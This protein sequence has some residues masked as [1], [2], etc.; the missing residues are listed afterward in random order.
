[1]AGTGDDVYAGGAGSDLIAYAVLGSVRVDLRLTGPQ[2]TGGGGRDQLIGVERV[3]TSEGDDVLIGDD[4]SNTFRTEAGDDVV[5]GGGGAL[6]ELDGQLGTD[7]L[8]YAAAPAGVRVDLGT[9]TMQV[10]GGG[11]RDTIAGFENLVGSPYA[12]EALEG[13]DGA[14]LITGLGGADRLFALGGNDVL[15][16]RDGAAD[17]AF[18]A[19]GVDTVTADVAGVDAVG[20]DCERTLLDTRPDTRIVSGPTGLTRDATPAFG[21]RATKPGSTFKCAVDGG[22]Y[23]ACRPAHTTARLRDGAHTLRARARDRLGALDLTPAARTFS[24]DATRPRITRARISRRVLRYRLSEN[25]R[26]VIRAHG[27]TRR[28]SGHRGANRARLP[29]G[30]RLVRLTAI[31]VAGNRSTAFA[32]RKDTN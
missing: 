13:T 9:A 18:C 31:D 1:M 15:A 27:R 22:P 28:R 30:V 20:A 25:A 21:L 11:G 29:R 17:D 23:R 3:S 16:V 6:D 19:A 32:R 14:N 2:Q 10:T 26:V 12:D 24:T 7:T 4:A 8:S 5:I